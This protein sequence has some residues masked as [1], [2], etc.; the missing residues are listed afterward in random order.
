MKK[1]EPITINETMMKDKKL[2]IGMRYLYREGKEDDQINLIPGVIDVNVQLNDNDLER[3]MGD[4]RLYDNGTMGKLAWFY[5]M[6]NL[7]PGDEIGLRIDTRNEITLETPKGKNNKKTRASTDDNYVPVLKN[8]GAKHVHYAALECPT[9]TVWYPENE[10]DLYVAMGIV[11]DKLDFTYLHSCSQEMIN[12]HGLEDFTE[13]S[14]RRS[15]PDAFVVYQPT[16]QKMLAEV[17]MK[18][19]AFK[20]NH[21]KDEV[22]VLFCWVNDEMDKTVLPNFVVALSDYF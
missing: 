12:R 15:K 11:Y 20:G 18:S 2:S 8:Q 10:K 13:K 16:K 19:S 1:S 4:A 14:E 21:S 17:K 22:D 9:R 3:K 6:F 5:D 7:K